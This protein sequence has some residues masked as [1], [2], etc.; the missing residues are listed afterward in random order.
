M[1]EPKKRK[2]RC[3]D[4]CGK[5]C[6]HDKI[7][8][9]Q[10][11]RLAEMLWDFSRKAAGVTKVEWEQLHFRGRGLHRKTARILLKAGVKLP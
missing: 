5:Q 11:E 1:S 4:D 7:T 2:L 3:P 8:K 10:I 6:I 9:E